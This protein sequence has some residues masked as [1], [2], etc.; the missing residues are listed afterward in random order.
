[1]RSLESLRESA[2]ARLGCDVSD[3]SIVERNH[4]YVVFSDLDG[5][6]VTIDWFGDT[7]EGGSMT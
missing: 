6:T 4:D 5:Y 7:V 1:M 3:C 2:A